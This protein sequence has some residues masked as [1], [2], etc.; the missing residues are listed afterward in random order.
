MGH[1]LGARVVDAQISSLTEY[2]LSGMCDVELMSHIHQYA[3]VYSARD[4]WIV[5]S[6]TGVPLFFSLVCPN[7]VK[8]PI[9]LPQ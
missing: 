4:D 3:G 9:S 1:I 7:S 5:I 6:L 8:A 2:L